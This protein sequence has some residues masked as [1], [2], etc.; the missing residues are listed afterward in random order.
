MRAQN[1][2]KAESMLFWFSSES[3]P[4]AAANSCSQ[5]SEAKRVHGKSTGVL[6]GTGGVGQVCP[7]QPLLVAISSKS[8][9]DNKEM[10]LGSAWLDI[11]PYALFHLRW[12][13]SKPWG[14]QHHQNIEDIDG[15]ICGIKGL[16]ATG[17]GPVF[18]CQATVFLAWHPWK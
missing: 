14:I 4:E 1:P 16:R 10:Q 17:Q 7:V 3:S 13:S 9:W 11:L 12:L 2:V 5:A 8:Q 15:K 6:S 18:L